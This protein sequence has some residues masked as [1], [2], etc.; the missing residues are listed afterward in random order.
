MRPICLTLFLFLAAMSGAIDP[1]SAQD[2]RIYRVEVLIFERQY[3]NDSPLDEKWPRNISLSYPRNTVELQEITTTGDPVTTN[4][5]T[6][7]A[8]STADIQRLPESQLKLTRQRDALER[9]SRLRT[10]FHAAWQQPLLSPA[11]APTIAL[12]GGNGYGEHFELEGSIKIS[13]SHYVHLDTDLWFSEFV[14]NHGQQPEYW[15]ALPPR[16]SLDS[17]MSSKGGL[18]GMSGPEQTIAGVNGDGTD[19]AASRSSADTTELEDAPALP[20]EEVYEDP[21]AEFLKSPYF[22]ENIVTFR[23]SRR[24]RSNELHYL[25]HPRLGMLIRVEPV[26]VRE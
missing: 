3:R 24:M 22:I 23:Q 2:S 4:D 18:M 26:K 14:P 1:A 16:P 15:L 21:Q 5:G 11:N 7:E 12:T 25:D 20:L 19:T 13:V 10:L 9:D 8:A 6:Q 17:T